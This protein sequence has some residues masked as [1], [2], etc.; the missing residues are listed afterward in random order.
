[1]QN[2]QPNTEDLAP[3]ELVVEFTTALNELEQA[4]WVVSPISGITPPHD[5]MKR[6]AELIGRCQLLL[7]RIGQMDRK[8]NGQAGKLAARFQLVKLRG[9]SWQTAGKENGQSPKK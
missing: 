3:R 7:N 4:L 9:E 6:T 5:F 8:L 1:M 2:H